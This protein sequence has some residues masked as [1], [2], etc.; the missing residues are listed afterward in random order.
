MK[1]TSQWAGVLTSYFAVIEFI[2][3]MM[4]SQVNYRYPRLLLT[5]YEWIYFLVPLAGLVCLLTGLLGYFSKR[6]K[7]LT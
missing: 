2:L 5:F 3:R 4:S 1:K 7:P 6:G